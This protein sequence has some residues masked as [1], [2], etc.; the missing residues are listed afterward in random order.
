MCVGIVV[1]GRVLVNPP[2]L[3]VG[4]PELVETAGGRVGSDDTG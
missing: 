3:E 2:P 1:L 4:K